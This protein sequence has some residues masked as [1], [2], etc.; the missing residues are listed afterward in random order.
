MESSPVERPRRRYLPWFLV[1]AALSWFHLG[2][3][4]WSVFA[5]HS[6]GAVRAVEID[7][8]RASIPELMSLPGVGRALA[9]RIVLSR[10]RQ[11]P[12]RVVQDLARVDGIGGSTVD[13]LRP[14][15]VV[16][17]GRSR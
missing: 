13:R 10:L 14:F 6:V 5:S 8:N 3:L 2:R 7:P 15:L 1:G 12:F 4:G 17:D 16:S 11:G 9:T